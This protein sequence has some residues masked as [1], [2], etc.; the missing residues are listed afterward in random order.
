MVEVKDA[1]TDER[2]TCS[3]GINVA[4]LQWCLKY[5]AAAW[6][7]LLVEFKACDIAAIPHASDGKFRLHRCKVL[8]QVT[9]TELDKEG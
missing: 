6:P 8:R 9:K 4:T 3:R 1:D 7:F 5:S 2:D